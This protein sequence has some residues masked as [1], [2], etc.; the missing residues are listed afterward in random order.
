M[1]VDTMIKNGDV[2]TDSTGKF[3]KISDSDA[4]FQRALICIGA[5]LGSFIYDRELGSQAEQVDKYDEYAVQKAELIINEALAQFE[6][7]YAKV[8]EFSDTI[9]L[10]ITIGNESRTEEVCS[11][12]NL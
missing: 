5:K 12:G 3:I 11:N 7:T 4:L 10:E 2:A 1:I 8:L 6:D 9:K